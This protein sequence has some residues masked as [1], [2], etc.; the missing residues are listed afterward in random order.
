MSK[1]LEEVRALIRVKHYSIETEQ[2]RAGSTTTFLFTSG[3]CQN[4]Q[5]PY[6]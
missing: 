3:G 4:V 5:S 2:A 1:L 6:S